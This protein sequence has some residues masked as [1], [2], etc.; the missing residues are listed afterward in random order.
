MNILVLNG[1]PKGEYSITLQTVRYLEILYPQHT[2]EVLHV[3]QRIKALEKNFAP[4]VEALN[5]ADLLF[6]SY[7]VYTFIAPSQLHR[8]IELTKAAVAEGKVSLAGKYATQIST[9]KHFYDVTAHRYVQD[10][11][12]DLALKYIRGLSADMDD[13]TTEKGQKEARDFFEFVCWNVEQDSY[14][15]APMAMGVE[16][17]AAYEAGYVPAH[18]TVTVPEGMA[19]DKTG[20]VV[21]IADFDPQETQLPAMIARFQA[22]MPR[23]TRVINIREYP[24]QGGCLGCFKCAITG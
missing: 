19:E 17:Y 24:F 22:V 1:S 15:S 14:E 10:N 12:H 16:E 20:D 4:A 5:R 3:G 21:I 2:F 7:P 23:K 18:K 6:F 9:S 13:L 11:C 8:F